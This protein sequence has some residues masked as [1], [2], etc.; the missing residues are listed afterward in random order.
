MFTGVG[1]A[2]E[3]VAQGLLAGRAWVGGVGC[4]DIKGLLPAF[5]ENYLRT[6]YL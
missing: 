1:L 5:V 3:C 6:N 4:K 2:A